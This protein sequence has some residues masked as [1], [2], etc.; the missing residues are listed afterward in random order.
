MT[1]VRSEARLQHSLAEIT[2]LLEKHRVLDVARHTARRVPGA[3]SSR[4]CSIA[5]ISPSCT[6]ACARCTPPTSPTCSKRCPLEDRQHGLGADCAR[7]GRDRVRRSVGRRSRVAGRRDAA[8]GSGRR[9]CRPST[10]KTSAT[11]SESLPDDVLDELSRALES[12]DRIRVRGLDPVRRR[13]GRPLHDP[14]LGGGAGDATRSQQVL[15]DLRRRGE[16]PPQTDRVFVTDA[17]HVL[18][19]V[20][21]AAGAAAQR[22]LDADRERDER[23]HHHASARTTTRATRSRRSSATTSSRRRSS[24]IA[25]SSSAA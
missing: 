22:P 4:T 12:G 15:A 11:S 10:P 8:R 1:T 18:R 7:A 24:T 5:R 14:R 19:G 21:A 25:A 13:H 6:S 9:C 16:L 3:T 2:R 23:R 17:R 20:G